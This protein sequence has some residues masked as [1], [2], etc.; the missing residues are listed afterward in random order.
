[1][2]KILF[3]STNNKAKPVSFREALLRGQAPDYGLYM[4]VSIPKL[5]K[6]EINSFKNKGYYRSCC[7]NRPRL[8]L[9][10]FYQ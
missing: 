2:P 4:P 7:Y 5:A 10:F 6:E 9:E 1:M 3:R 8:F